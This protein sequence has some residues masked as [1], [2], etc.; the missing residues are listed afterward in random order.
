MKYWVYLFGS[1]ARKEND[2]ESDLDILIIIE[3]SID[4]YKI[5]EEIEHK[6]VNLYKKKPSF[7]VYTLDRIRD[8]YSNGTLFSWHLF[9][10]SSFI[11]SNSTI[12]FLNELG[13]PKEY[14]KHQ[15]EFK[16][17]LWLI[18]SINKDPK[19]IEKSYVLEVSNFYIACR[20]IGII[21]S[22][23]INNPSQFSPY[24]IFVINKSF[25]VHFE[26]Y[27]NYRRIKSKKSTSEVVTYTMEDCLNFI[28]DISEV[29][30]WLKKIEEEY[31]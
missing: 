15:E 30:I 17:F 4:F 9:Q 8:Y 16:L 6:I 23:L 10:E 5:K 20:N 1:V 26:S 27:K 21:L 24:S 14:R 22:D 25:P 7:S 11:L 3:E 28:K 12:N 2:N 13:M 29:E 31:I 19:Y 18:E